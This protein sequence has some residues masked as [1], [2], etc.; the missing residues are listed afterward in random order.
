MTNDPPPLSCSEGGEGMRNLFSVLYSLFF[1]LSSFLCPLSSVPPLPYYSITP[2]L[3]SAS[4]RG[5]GVTFGL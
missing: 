5:V 4:A 1:A 3:R 2:L